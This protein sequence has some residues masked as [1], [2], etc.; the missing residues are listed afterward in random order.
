MRPYRQRP[1]AVALV[2]ALTISACGSAEPTG[3]DIGIG[4]ATV[5]TEP[6]PSTSAAP[7]STTTTEAVASTTTVAADPYRTLVATARPEITQLEAFDAPDGERLPLPFTVPNPHQFGGP[8]TLMVTEGEHGDE[9]LKVQIPLRPNGSEGWI[10]ASGYA[11]SET[12]VHADVV[13]S[14]QR[15]VVYDGDEVIAESTAVIGAEESPTPLGTFYV[16]ARRRNPETEPWLGP[17]A[18][19]LS[20]YSE[21]FETF[22]GGLP[23]IA[24]H[25]TNRPD[26]VGE[27]T[28]NGCIRVPNDV[29]NFLAEHVPLGAPVTVL[30]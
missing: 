9:W 6:P 15:V 16:A 26:D 11:T 8:L 1:L 10:R 14:E 5:P 7:R 4:L 29:I 28:T 2:V 20:G 30:T 13:L 24:I 23:V 19:V 18:L 25:G 17:W 21:A 3:A 27:A 22:S 12:R